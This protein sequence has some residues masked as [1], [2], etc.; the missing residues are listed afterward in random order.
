MW[1]FTTK[2]ILLCNIIYKLPKVQHQSL[3]VYF[4]SVIMFIVLDKRQ[5][6]D[7]FIYKI[8]AIT[9]Y[10]RLGIYDSSVDRALSTQHLNAVLQHCS[11]FLVT[12][13][14]FPIGRQACIISW[15]SHKTYVHHVMHKG[16]TKHTHMHKSCVYCHG[17]THMRKRLYHPLTRKANRPCVVGGIVFGGH[18]VGSLVVGGRVVGGLVVVGGVVGSQSPVKK[19]QGV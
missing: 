5:T 3:T 11:K 4:K 15:L 12:F 7:V 17:I 14:V 2:H 19:L 8:L 10:R 13:H 6:L 1:L 9:S 18:V 16:A